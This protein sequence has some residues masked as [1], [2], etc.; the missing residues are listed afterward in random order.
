MEMREKKVAVEH[1]EKEAVVDSEK[2]MC[3]WMC[4]AENC[5][6][7]MPITILGN[8][9]KLNQMHSNNFKHI[10]IYLKYLV[11]TMKYTINI[12]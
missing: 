9:L 8:T 6:S 11:N 1:V 3:R 4:M 10:Q 2:Q 5:D 12:L 7:K